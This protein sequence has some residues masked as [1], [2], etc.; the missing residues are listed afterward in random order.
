MPFSIEASTEPP[1]VERNRAPL[2]VPGEIML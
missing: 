2:A 1:G